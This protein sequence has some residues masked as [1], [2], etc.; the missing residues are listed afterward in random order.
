MASSMY[1]TLD[2]STC[3]IHIYHEGDSPQLNRKLALFM[4]QIVI[5]GN[6]TVAIDL[7]MESKAT[8]TGLSIQ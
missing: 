2:A 8:K 7:G 6:G 4:L 3:N 5:A 1:F